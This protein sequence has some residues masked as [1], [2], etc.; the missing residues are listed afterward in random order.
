MCH[1]TLPKKKTPGISV[2]WRISQK[3]TNESKKEKDVQYLSV[4]IVNHV[5]YCAKWLSFIIFKHP[6]FK[7][8][9]TYT[10]GCLYFPA[11]SNNKSFHGFVSTNNIFI[12]SSWRLRC[13]FWFDSINSSSISETFY[14]KYET[15][16]LFP[17]LNLSFLFF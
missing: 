5:R 10:F 11:L 7:Q 17:N 4:F 9:F 6:K 8:N 3:R 15:S 2:A 13:V 1:P 14:E 16:F 12:W